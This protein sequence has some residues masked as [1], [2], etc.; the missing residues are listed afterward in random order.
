MLTLRHHN[1]EKLFAQEESVALLACQTYHI[2]Q[3]SVLTI[4][5]HLIKASYTVHDATLFEEVRT[6]S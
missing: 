5:R 6:I 4:V 2:Q 1:Q 3:L